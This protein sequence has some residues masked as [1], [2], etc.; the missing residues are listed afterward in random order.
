MFG[1]LYTVPNERYNLEQKIENNNIWRNIKMFELMPF[2]H[3]MNRVMRY[4]PFR[5]MDAFFENQGK[6]MSS[7][8]TDIIDNGNSFTVNAELPGFA[9]EDIHIDADNDCL[10]I[11]AERTMNENEEKQD[12]IRRERFY[13]SYKRSFDITGI[14]RD[15]IEAA[16]T[17]GVLSITLPKLAAEAPAAR[18]ITIS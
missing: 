9:K 3:R 4:D 18:S 7:I 17:D 14:D 2:D 12:Y 10:T 16:Y 1:K 11:S 15:R 8:S 6:M 5:E 13:G